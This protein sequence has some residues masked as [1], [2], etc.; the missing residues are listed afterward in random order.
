MYNKSSQTLAYTNDIV[1]VGRSIEALK[2]IMKKSMKTAQV[3]GLTINMQKTKYMEVT[4]KPTNAEMLKTD[5]QEYGKVKEF[6]Y[7]GTILT[8]DNDMTTE[9]K[10]QITI[11]NKTSYGLKKQLNLTNSKC[12]TKCMLY[13]TLTRPILTYEIECWPLSKKNG[14]SS[15]SLKEEY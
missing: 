5:D 10:H 4:K 13:K 2:E 1:T 8:E 6:K 9:I 14:L 3:M 7:L 11:A 15:K 12:Q